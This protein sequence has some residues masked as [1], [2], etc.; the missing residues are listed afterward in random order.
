MK[1]VKKL[2]TN[3]DDL[4]FVGKVNDEEYFLN[5][6]DDSVRGWSFMGLRPETE[7]TLK[8]RMREIDPEDILG[9]SRKDFEMISNYF[10]YDKF[11]DDMEENWYDW[12]DVQVERDEDGEHLFLGFGSGQD[13]FGYWKNNKI[14]NYSDYCK[15]F[16]E[17]GLNERD[18][19]YVNEIIQK[20]KNKNVLKMTDSE[21]QREKEMFTSYFLSK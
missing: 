19:D 13:I 5:L 18:F 2:K 21:K 14:Q 11:L 8:E 1:E 4:V 17:I 9:L 7:E 20:R 3:K 12:H 10:D 6:G 15:H 16:E